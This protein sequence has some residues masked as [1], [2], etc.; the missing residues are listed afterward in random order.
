L[1]SFHKILSQAMNTAFL[2]LD[3][4]PELRIIIYRFMI[5]DQRR[6]RWVEHRYHQTRVLCFP[7]FLHASRLL[8][9][10]ALPIFDR[11]ASEEAHVFVRGILNLY[12]FTHTGCTPRLLATTRRL[13]VMVW[14]ELTRPGDDWAKKELY[15]AWAKESIGLLRGFPR[16]RF[17]RLQLDALWRLPVNFGIDVLK[18]LRDL[19]H[20]EIVGDRRT[21]QELGR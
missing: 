5:L 8:R 3:L 10:E 12:V 2:L 11:T 6:Y 17:L 7:A 9:D 18:E 13:T 15:C 16:L 19:K 4:P 1:E 21:M 20:V 14:E